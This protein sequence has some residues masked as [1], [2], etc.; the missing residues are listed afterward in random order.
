VK[1]RVVITGSGFTTSIGNNRSDVLRSLK[2][3]R[4][5]IDILP[6]LPQEPGMCHLAGTIK[7]FSFPGPRCE[8]WTFPA[9]C[10]IER[11]HLRSMNPHVVY[12]CHALDQAI[13]QAALPPSLVSHP[14]SGALCASGGSMSTLYQNL[15]VMETEGVH[16][17]YPLALP[18]SIPGTLNYNLAAKYK[19]KGSLLGF[20]SACASSAH[21]MGYAY[22]QIMLGRQ[23]LCFVVGAEDC[24]RFSI[25]PFAGVRALSTRAAAH[26]TPSPFDA[27]RDGFV[28]TGG[29]TTLVLESLDSAQKRGV[30]ILAEMLGWAEAADGFNVMAPEPNGEGLSRAMNSALE[31]SGVNA[32]EID[33]LNAHATGTTVGDLAE[34]RAI[35]SVFA[36]GHLPWI[37]STKALTGHGL[38]L[39]GVMEAAFCVLALTEGFMPISAKINQLDPDFSDMPILTKPESH[40]PRTVMTNSSGFGGSNVS[41]ILRRWEN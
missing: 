11:N 32:A 15:H 1:H 17:C 39:A 31:Q 22:D 21:A 35:R 14:R 28:G 2:E 4:S 18:A 10:Q 16:R 33:Y 41:L 37:S 19:I 27:A 5:G 24:N 9:S 12:A 20:A 3:A 29:A 40:A 13:A 6:E 7:D 23:D 38:C 25:L 26:L 8:D 36:Q 30:P 34:I